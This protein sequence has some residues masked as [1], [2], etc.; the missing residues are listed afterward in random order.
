MAETSRLA[1]PLVQAAQAQKHVTVNE[2]FERLDALSQLTL[3][4]DGQATPPLSPGQGEVHGV[5]AGAV[6]A[7]TGHDGKLAVF[8][9]GGWF[10]V[11]PLVGWRGWRSDIGAAVSFDGSG[12]IEG[13]GS[14]SANG[15]GFV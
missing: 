7:W 8:S 2:A 3:V 4:S 14:I 9:N 5:G 15:A 6:D 13:A 10:F 1:L 11:T 12:W